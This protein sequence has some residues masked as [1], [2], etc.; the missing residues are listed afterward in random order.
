MPPPLGHLTGVGEGG[1]GGGGGA[2]VDDGGGAAL[3]EYACTAAVLPRATHDLGSGVALG[4][5][6]SVGGLK[7]AGVESMTTSGTVSQ[8]MVEAEEVKPEMPF[9]TFQGTGGENSL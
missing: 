4:S 8:V 9:Q 6:G 7:L 2:F 5:L 3:L 1:G